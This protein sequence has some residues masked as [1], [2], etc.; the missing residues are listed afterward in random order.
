MAKRPR[1]KS[2]KST[3]RKSAKRAVPRI[4]RPRN[5]I[6]TEI[7][8]PDIPLHPQPFPTACKV[9]NF[10]FSSAIGGNDPVTHQMPADPTTQVENAFRTARRI[11]EEAGGSVDSIGKVT[12]FVRDRD[13]RPIVNGV[14]QKIFSNEKS[15]PVRH[16]VPFELPPGYHVQIEFL[17]VL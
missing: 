8:A 11:M 4:S 6:R 3:A 13:L 9:G 10:V 7:A 14:W 17:A 15:R 1:R 2:A 16:L 5:A 12:V